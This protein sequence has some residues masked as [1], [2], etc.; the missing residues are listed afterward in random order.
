MRWRDRWPEK[1]KIISA[2][3]T[4][5]AV[6]WRKS[7]PRDASKLEAVVHFAELHLEII[8]TVVADSKT[9]DV[10]CEELNPRRG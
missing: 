10:T 3:S 6:E 2:R 7:I 8:E 1:F 9:I 4:M 5:A